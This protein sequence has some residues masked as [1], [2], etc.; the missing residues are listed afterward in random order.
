MYH[1]IITLWETK[2]LSIS[3]DTQRNCLLKIGLWELKFVYHFVRHAMKLPIKN[4][5]TENK[6]MK[7]PIENIRCMIQVIMLHTERSWFSRSRWTVK[8]KQKKILTW[9]WNVV[10]RISLEH[11][12][13]CCSSVEWQQRNFL[14]W[15]DGKASY[16]IFFPFPDFFGIT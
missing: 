8:P 11:Q 13:E 16:K 1:K 6:A 9:R 12:E 5:F 4:W 10:Q 3:Y 15:R 7:L 14:P 2:H